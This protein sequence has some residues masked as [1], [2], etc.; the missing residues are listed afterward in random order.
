M[1]NWIFPKKSIINTTLLEGMTD[2]HAHLL[3]NVDGGSESLMDSIAVLK[4]MEGIGVK[5]IFLTPHI[6]KDYPNNTPDT[7]YAKFVIL[8]DCCPSGIELHL[9]AEYM[10]DD[11][12]AAH[13]KSGLFVLPARQVLIETSRL[14]APD[15][16]LTILFNL[17][18]DGYLPVIAHPEL[19]TYMKQEDYSY[20]KNKGYKLQL[21][22]FSLAGLYGD[23][24][25]SIACF[26]L[27]KGY[28]DYVGSD[29]CRLSEYEKGLKQLRLSEDHVRLVRKLL[30]NNELL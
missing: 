26:L 1:L 5:R 9:A 18:L 28:Y 30:D 2:V 17:V 13:M 12:F 14:S 24:P 19:Y 11:G 25:K 3:P 21:N 29:F 7:L 20:L 23:R 10:L 22:L 4:R 15:N 27:N 16:F 6:M 8:K